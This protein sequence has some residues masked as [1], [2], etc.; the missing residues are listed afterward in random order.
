MI[1]TAVQDIKKKIKPAL[2]AIDCLRDPSVE[3]REQKAIRNEFENKGKIV[4]SELVAE[5]N[6]SVSNLLDEGL[7]E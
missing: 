5:E 2:E 6:A 3:E 4:L 1:N 7:V